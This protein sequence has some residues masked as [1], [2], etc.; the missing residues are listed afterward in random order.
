MTK[1]TI[2]FIGVGRMGQPMASRLI[3]AGVGPAMATALTCSL[4]FNPW[5]VP[6]NVTEAWLRFLE[7]AEAPGLVR[8]IFDSR[9]ILE[10][11]EAVPGNL[12]SLA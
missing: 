3:A 12:A 5:P 8:Q 10:V 7:C 1:E 2:G 6:E 11:D 9:R 4:D